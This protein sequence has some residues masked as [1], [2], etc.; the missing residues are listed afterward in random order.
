MDSKLK[1][2]LEDLLIK[3]E[4][5]WRNKSRETWLACKD[6]NTRFFHTS[7]LIR[8]RSN[9]VD[10]LK[11]DSG[12]WFSERSAIGGTLVN[13]FSNIFSS[14]S[15]YI[16][17]E[18]LNLFAPSISDEENDLLCSIPSEIEVVQ[19]LSSL[20]STKAPGPDGFTALF[21]KKYWSSV[22][23]DVMSF[24][25]K[26]F[27]NNHLLKEHNHTCIALVPKQSGFHSVHHFRPISLCNIVYKLITKIMASRLKILLPKIISPL[28]SAFVPNQNIQDNN[29]LAHEL[30]HSF[31]NKKGKGGFMFLKMDMEKAFDNMEWDFFLEIL[32]KLGFHPT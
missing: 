26:F 23:G 9:V 6:L 13:H 16:D 20:G 29:I 2:D 4:I 21:F 15:P 8:R 17:E 30:L 25:F 12:A 1:L 10:F 11:I 27:Q 18:M 22:K 3:E 7:T 24:V 14:S 32:I 19:A 5:L 28:Q 31:K